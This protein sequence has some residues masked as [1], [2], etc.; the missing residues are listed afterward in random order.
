[1]E[2][3]GPRYEKDPFQVPKQQPLPPQPGQPA[4]KERED[5]GL[6]QR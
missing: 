4:P 6:S 3:T 1:M 2:N 5:E